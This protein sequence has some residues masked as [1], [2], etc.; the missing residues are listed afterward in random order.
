MTALQTGFAKTDI[1]PRVGVELA[2]FG[3]FLNRHSIGIR[4]RLWARAMAAKLRDRTVIIVGCDLVGIPASIIK[5]VREIVKE[6]TGVAEKNVMISCTHTHSGPSIRGLSGWGDVD[7]PYM[8]LLPYR[9][10]D[11]CVK[12]VGSMEE[13]EMGYAEVPCEGIGLNRVYDK[14]APPL[15][16]VL[17]DDWRPA[18]PELTDT[19]CQVLTFKSM[20]NLKGF[21]SYFGCHP[22]V[23]CAQTRYIHGDYAGVAT[24]NLERES[25][26]SVGLFLQGALGDV[27]SCVVHKPE[28]E[29]LLAL[30]II[31]ARYA[32]CARKGIQESKIIDTESINTITRKVRFSRKDVPLQS[33]KKDLARYEDILKKEGATDQDGSLRMAVVYIYALRS[34]I[35]KLSSGREDELNPPIELQAI[36]I[37]PVVFFGAPFEV[38][39]G[40]KNDLKSKAQSKVPLLMSVTNGMYG[41]APENKKIGVGEY[42]D[43][44]VPF[45]I[46]YL[47]YANIHNELV[48]NFLDMERSLLS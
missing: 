47:P 40:I 2:G 43:S 17:R 38:F 1:T 29:A 34:F 8:E 16:E 19:M 5:R 26:G 28:Q 44:V 11:A 21:I 30:D 22:V 24:N 48:E 33:L 36:N 6:K 4:D 41:Y 32:N 15:E 23:C 18:K 9:I 39:Q 20:G 31:A 27:N 10:A 35:E 13:S 3:P 46:Q 25:P 42:A 45:I 37:G 7:L 12:A 14:D